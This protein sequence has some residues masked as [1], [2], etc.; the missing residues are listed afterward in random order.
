[1][2]SIVRIMLIYLLK[3][4]FTVFDQISVSLNIMTTDG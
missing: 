4:L 2:F 3:I 1:M